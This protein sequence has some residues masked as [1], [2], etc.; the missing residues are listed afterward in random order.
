MRALTGDS[1]SITGAVAKKGIA[2]AFW[3]AGSRRGKQRIVAGRQ[4]V[5]AA[6]QHAQLQVHVAQFFVHQSQQAQPQ[7]LG[8]VRV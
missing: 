2:N 7:G 4:I 3:A 8:V 1:L 6:L 5:A